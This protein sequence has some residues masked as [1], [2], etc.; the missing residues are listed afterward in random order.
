MDD[1]ERRDHGGQAIGAASPAA[2]RSRLAL[3]W[4]WND[5]L[6]ALHLLSAFALSGALILFWVVVL[7]VRRAELPEQV[8]GLGRLMSVGT[9]VVSVGSLGAI[10]FGVWLAISLDVVQV[11]DGWVIAAIVLWAIATET[12]RRSGVE[13]EPC[14]ERARELVAAGQ[15]AADPSLRELA[16]TSRG[17]LLHAIATV[18]VILILADMI[19]KPGA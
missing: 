4:T 6:L 8:A 7:S 12:G 19:W 5:W 13:Y 17:L 18:G 2:S 1:A 3:R 9:V 15:T 10:I 11:W 16:N 14:L